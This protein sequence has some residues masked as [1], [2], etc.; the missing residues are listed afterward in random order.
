ME[1][2]D[3]CTMQHCWSLWRNKCQ[4]VSVGVCVNFASAAAAATA[5]DF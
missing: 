2:P 5:V 1:S 4:Y 3:H